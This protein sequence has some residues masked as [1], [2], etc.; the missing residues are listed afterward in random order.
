MTASERRK[1]HAENQRRYSKKQPPEWTIWRGM[2]QRCCDSH[3]IMYYC[4]G[5]RGIEVCDRWLERG[6]GFKNFMEDMGPMPS[7]DYSLDRISPDK[8]YSK[9][10]CRWWERSK[11]F[12]SSRGCFKSKEEAEDDE[13][14]F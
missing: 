8:G 2:K 5:G 7:S 4:Y 10:N 12:A 6:V 1:R 9:E 11:N 3:H 14:P 13:V